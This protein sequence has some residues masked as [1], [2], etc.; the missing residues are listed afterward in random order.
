MLNRFNKQLNGDNENKIFYNIITES[1][2]N[3]MRLRSDVALL[4]SKLKQ[5]DA[6][7]WLLYSD[8]SYTFFAGFLALL[9]L[10]KEVYVC[11][12]NSASWL[13]ECESNFEAVLSDSRILIKNKLFVDFNCDE[14]DVELEDFLLTGEERVNFFTS[15]STGVPK[16][17]EKNLFC[18]IKEI[19]T[20]EKTFA[21]QVA[22]GVFYSTV[23]HLHIYGLLF[24]LIWPFVTG[25]YCTNPFIEY[26]EQLI[27]ME[28]LN[29][30]IVLVSS[31]AFISRIDFSLDKVSPSIVFSS[32]GP[33]AYEASNKAL[34][35][36]SVRPVEVY[37]S[38]ETGG[39]A[40]RQQEHQNTP[41][42]PFAGVQFQQDNDDTWFNANHLYNLNK[43]K[44]DDILSFNDFGYF[45]LKGRK[46]RIV[47][48][49][50]KRISLTEIEMFLEK[51]EFVERCV[52]L[53]IQGKRQFIGC[54]LILSEQGIKREKRLGKSALFNWFKL[55][56]KKHFEAVTIPRKWRIVSQLPETTQ[57]KLDT[58]ALRKLFIK[59]ESLI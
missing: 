9:S 1:F 38:T 37:G 26:P 32:G 57:S 14:Q 43:I 40:Y 10:K 51:L 6:Q 36:F 34:S 21:N 31:P 46:D 29:L 16:V 19:E 28:K 4:K 22:Q 35:Y 54:V 58:D 45:Q 18:L 27:L 41:W 30:P 15:G 33:L 42:R 3:L 49:E 50:E 11:S 17:V 23:S 52:A 59:S 24:K 20:L 13:E 2:V 53:I 7:S 39:I 47:K 12:N 44:L 25:R 55:K 48:L 56:M 8:D 5:N